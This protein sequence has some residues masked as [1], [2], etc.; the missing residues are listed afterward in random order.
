M[1]T[2]EL[3]KPAAKR[4]F[5]AWIEDWE[6]ESRVNPDEVHMARL[7]NKYGNLKLW[8]PDNERMCR[9]HPEQMKWFKGNKRAKIDKGWSVI[10]VY[11]D[12]TEDAEPWEVGDMLCKVIAETEQDEGVEVV[13]Q[14]DEI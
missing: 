14:Q 9:I 13:T 1:D 3:K 2:L 8:D 7:C 6:E 5:K 10:A 11:G 12:G 4:R